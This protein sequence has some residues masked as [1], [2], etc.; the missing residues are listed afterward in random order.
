MDRSNPLYG[1]NAAMASRGTI[2]VIGLAALLAACSSGDDDGGV[3]PGGGSADATP[4]T[5]ACAPD[6]AI[7]DTGLRTISAGGRD[8]QFILHVPSGYDRAPTALV[9]NFHGFTS[10]PTQQEYFSVMSEAADREGFAVA[11][12]QGVGNSF[13]AG[14]CCGTAADQG[15][16][17]VGFAA[18][19]IDAVAEEMC[20]DPARVYSTGLSNGGFMSYRLACELSD[21]IAAIAPVAG[22]MGIEDCTPSRAVPV[23]HFHGTAD[24]L[25]LYDGGGVT[26]FPSVEDTVSGWSERDGCSGDRQVSFE[27]GDALCE[28]WDACDQ[29]SA[30][31]LCVIDGGGHTWPGGRVPAV[32]GK[33]SQDL[34][35]TDRMWQFFSEH[36]LPGQ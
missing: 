22:V 19:L 34:I 5:G 8:R 20:L 13:N 33:T 26:G 4:L 12:P 21:R 24:A 30:V 9:L 35:A 15:L 29:E 11:Y 27:Q 10:D 18:A 32:A 3:D 17:D 25:V 14:A 2:H 6:A 28:R 23:L 1:I 31:E 36:P 7:P 16:D